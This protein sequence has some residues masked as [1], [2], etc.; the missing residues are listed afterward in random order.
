M[1]T[2][3]EERE[4]HYSESMKMLQD[5]MEELEKQKTRVDLAR[6]F[7]VLLRPIELSHAISPKAL[8]SNK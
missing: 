1:K 6:T 5:G 7:M 3:R 4:A 2:A 8:P